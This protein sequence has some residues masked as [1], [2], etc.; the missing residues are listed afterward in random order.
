MKNKRT[1]VSVV[2]PKILAW[3]IETSHNIVASYR[4]YERAGL[5]IPHQAVLQERQILCASW[6][7]IGDR[8]IHSAWATAAPSNS[9]ADRA[10]VAKLHRVLSDVDAV[11][12]HHG[13]AF[14]MKYFNARALYHGFEPIPNIIQIDTKKICKAK[15]LFN[16]NRLDYVAHFLGVGKK[17]KTDLDLWLACLRGDPKAMKE[18]VRYNRWDVALLKRVYKKLRPWVPAKVNW[19]L[20]SNA[21]VCTSCGSS[22]VAPIGRYDLTLKGK[23][24]RIKCGSCGAT[25]RGARFA[26]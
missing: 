23:W 7:L 12:H 14:D 26:K 25:F 18:M 4:L 1:N 9:K 17:V 3:D 24:H 2:K 15:F 8:E 11:V 5:Q 16:S 21:K 19:Q 13:D 20:F 10:I 6:S 22:N